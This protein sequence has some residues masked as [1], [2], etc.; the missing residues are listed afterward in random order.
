MGLYTKQYRDFFDS[1]AG[2]SLIQDVESIVDA[3]HRRA[4][5]AGDMQEAFG[6]MKRAAGVRLV[7]KKMHDLTLEAK[8]P[9]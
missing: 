2:K 4:E 6:Y 1:D 8:K 9:K 7:V 5:D 3:E